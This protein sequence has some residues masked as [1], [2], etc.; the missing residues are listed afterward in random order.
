MAKK[1]I[2]E[3]YFN[4]R[5]KQYPSDKHSFLTIKVCN[6]GDVVC[7]NVLEFFA[8]FIAGAQVLHMC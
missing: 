8:G 5:I 2:S 6:S 3:S 4:C 1:Y 7:K